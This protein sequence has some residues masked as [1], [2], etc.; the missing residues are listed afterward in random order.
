MISTFVFVAVWVFFSLLLLVYTPRTMYAYVVMQFAFFS[1]LLFAFRLLSCEFVNCDIFFFVWHYEYAPRSEQWKVRVRA[2]AHSNQYIIPNE[3]F[4]SWRVDF[5]H[6]PIRIS[7][8]CFRYSSY[9]RD[10]FSLS[11]SQ[12]FVCPSVSLVSF[13]LLLLC[14][15]DE[16]A[17]HSI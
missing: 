12:I 7:I 1:L 5:S 16:M 13:R 11:L 14:V 4:L 17:D 10:F 8:F 6:N 2:R 9:F 3:F 15:N